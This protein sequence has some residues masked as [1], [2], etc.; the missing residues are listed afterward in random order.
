MY[1]KLIRKWDSERELFTTTP[2]TTFTQ[3]APETTEFGEIT[4]NKGHYTVHGHSRSPNSVRINTT[5]Y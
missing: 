5:S 1:K 2:S 3:Y 4:Q